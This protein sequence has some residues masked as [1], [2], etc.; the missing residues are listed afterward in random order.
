ME[1]LPASQDKQLIQKQQQEEQLKKSCLG[2]D[3]HKEDLQLQ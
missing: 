3:M 1:Q 2:N